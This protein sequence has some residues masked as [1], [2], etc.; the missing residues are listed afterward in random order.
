MPS[1]GPD[2][3]IEQKHGRVFNATKDSN[4]GSDITRAGVHCDHLGAKEGVGVEGAEGHPG[5]DLAA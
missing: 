4:S 1:I 2:E 5:V 3:R